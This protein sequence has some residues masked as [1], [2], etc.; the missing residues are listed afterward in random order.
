MVSACIDAIS[1]VH[2]HEHLRQ[3]HLVRDSDISLETSPPPQES[4]RD[5][6]PTTNPGP[7]ADIPPDPASRSPARVRP[8][9]DGLSLALAQQAIRGWRVPPHPEC[10]IS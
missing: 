3:R 8:H 10:D 2:R 1:H 5:D 9:Y 4:D 6:G 7:S